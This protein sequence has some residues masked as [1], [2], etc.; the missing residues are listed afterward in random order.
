MYG[1]ITREIYDFCKEELP[2]YGER[3]SASL[4]GG[5]GLCPQWGPGA[6]PLVGVRW[7]KPPKAGA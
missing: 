3:E 2:L 4:Y 5:L 1:Y 7:T 6:K